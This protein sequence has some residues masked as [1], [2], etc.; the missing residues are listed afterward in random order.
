MTFD[1]ILQAQNL[2]EEQ[3]KAIKAAMKENKVFTAGEENLDIRYGKLKTDFDGVNGQLSEA[4]KLIEEMKKSEGANENLQAKIAEYE[5][6]ITEL[7]AEKAQVETEAALKVALLEA[8]A[9]DID[10][11]TFK[12]REKGEIELGDDGKVKGIDDTIAALKTQFPNQFKGEGNRKV[13]ENK[14]EEGENKNTVTP[15]QFRKMGYQ[16]RV[17][18]F[19]KNPELYET[20][21]KGE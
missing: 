6:R 21:S 20:L 18:L 3:V 2:D 19:N 8:N 5:G 11:L 10:Y 4:Q 9:E 15:D 13:L 1:E 17:D 12:I 14:L 16:Q 7:E